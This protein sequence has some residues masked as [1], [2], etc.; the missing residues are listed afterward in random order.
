MA[1]HIVWVNTLIKSLDLQQYTAPNH[2]PNQYWLILSKVQW[3][4]PVSKFSRDKSTLNTKMCSKLLKLHPNL[5]EVNEWNKKNIYQISTVS[6]AL[7]FAVC[8]WG[9]KIPSFWKW[10]CIS[11]TMT[12]YLRDGVF[13][14]A[15][16]LPQVWKTFWKS[17]CNKYESIDFF[18][19]HSKCSR[20]CCILLHGNP[21]C[22][23][24]LELKQMNWD[25]WNKRLLINYY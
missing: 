2:Y 18:S 17:Q 3:H 9:D 6:V 14:N 25:I 7:G 12:L 16:L 23:H 21:I 8:Y 5:P 24:V 13:T 19:D 4:S 20:T 1:T 15:I 22:I 11:Y 10:T